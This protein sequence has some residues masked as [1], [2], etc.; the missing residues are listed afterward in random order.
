MK[1]VIAPD[2]FKEC[3]SSA[4]VADAI[5]RGVLRVFPDAETVKVPMAD[6]GEGTVDA[7]VAAAGA[8]VKTRLVTGPLGDRVEARYAILENIAIIE[9][10]AASGLD[11]VPPQK[12]NPLK[13]TTY[14]TG[15]FV[16]AA[17]DD[18]AARIV[19]GVGGSATVDG[20][21]GMAQALGV[22][23]L[24][25]MWNDVDGCG[26]NLSKID[27]ID[28]SKLDPR[29]KRC[30]VEVACDVTNP[31]CGERGAARIYGPQK[32]ASAAMVDELDRGLAHLAH[33]IKR[34]VGV[35]VSDL[36]GA[37]AAGGL[38]AGLVA[39]LGAR[40]RSGVD[41]LIETT[42]L[43]DKVRDA[44]LIITG[45]GK[46]D[47][48]TLSGKLPLGVARLGARFGVPTIAIAG[49]VEGDTKWFY[50][51]GFAAI[52]TIPPG[53][54]TIKT[55]LKNAAAWIADATERAMRLLQLGQA[56]G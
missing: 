38:A 35:D 46:L 3:L 44:D 47:D 6:G 16:R 12:R 52:I 19:V 48:Q 43:E 50:D 29:V 28:M 15:E 9:M 14:G 21:T 53:P 24:D 5:G 4:A 32:G 39:F 34:D 10:A 23:F 51:A 33:I 26:G 36:P 41:L 49:S 31:L 45:E 18:G 20:G 55:S 37:G 40:I 7:F 30:T 17:L 13:T 27:R 56:F 22:R 42:R 11:L 25:K 2:S 54:A 8:S 1:V